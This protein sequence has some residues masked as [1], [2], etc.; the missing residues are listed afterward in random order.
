MLLGRGI[1][2]IVCCVGD[3]DVAMGKLRT[4]GEFVFCWATCQASVTYSSTMSEP[5]ECTEQQAML[6]QRAGWLSSQG[7]R[8]NGCLLYL[9]SGVIDRSSIL[10]IYEFSPLV[11]KENQVNSSCSHT[12]RSKTMYI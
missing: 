8:K 6:P 12:L 2:A 7:P 10:V 5:R 1:R 3:Y 9:G 4:S 11:L